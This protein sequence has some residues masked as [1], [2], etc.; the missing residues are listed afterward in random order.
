MKVLVTGAGG[1][2]GRAL[3]SRARDYDEIEIIATGALGA[4]NGVRSLDVTDQKSVD[5]AVDSI[6]PDAIVHLAGVVGQACERD[7]S[8]AE[9]VNVGAVAILCAAAERYGVARLVLPSTAGVYETHNR[10]PVDE[11]EPT[12]A[13]SVYAESKLR[14]ELVLQSFDLSTVALR[15][16]NVFGP[17]V[18]TSIVAHL[19]RSTAD[20]PAKLFGLDAFVRDYVHASDVADALLAAAGIELTEIHCVVNIA[21]GIAVSNRDLIEALAPL[22]SLYFTVKKQ[23]SS[24]SCADISLA[25]KLLGFSPRRTLADAKRL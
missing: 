1:Q 22:H 5:A 24:Y 2:L 6:R 23:I 8:R 3:I 9:A 15:V 19:L 12:T 21:S 18:E 14:A 16:F 11:L 4:A 7:P 10:R 13:T 25:K 17:T 20:D